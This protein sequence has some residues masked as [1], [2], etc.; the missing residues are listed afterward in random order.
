M[1]SIKTKIIFSVSFLLLIIA[2]AIIGTS[3]QFVS[4]AVT[5]IE[6]K[7]NANILNLLYLFTENFMLPLSH[8]EVKE[9]GNRVKGALCDLLA[10]T[11]VRLK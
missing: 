4:S 9:V 5:R 10:A 6:E 7:A 1:Q 11:V 2:I 8:D 3:Y